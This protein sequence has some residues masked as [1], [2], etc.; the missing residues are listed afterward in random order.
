MPSSSLARSPS[1]LSRQVDAV[2]AASQV[3]VAV[4]AQ[5]VAETGG[6][7]TLP[8]LRVLVMVGTEGP[9][10]LSTVARGLGVHPSNATRTC[11]RLVQ[12]GLLARQD[13]PNDRRNVAVTLTVEG[14]RLVDSV[15]DHRRRAIER[16][17]RQLPARQRAHLA[18]VLEEFASVAGRTPDEQAT[19]LGWGVQ[20]SDLAGPA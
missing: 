6:T 18:S 14:R 7:V 2:V 3:L 11:Q 13:D 20:P 12:A 8:Q 5:S 19:A 1:K 10:N 9:L 17:L 16:M 15:M 4:V